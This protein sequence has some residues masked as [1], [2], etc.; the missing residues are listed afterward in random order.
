MNI[1][2][3]VEAAELHEG[4][5]YGPRRPSHVPDVMRHSARQRPGRPGTESGRRGGFS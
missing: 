4:G 1:F 2:K 5:S 3:Y